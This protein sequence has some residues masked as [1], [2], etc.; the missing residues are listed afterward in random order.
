MVSRLQ[1]RLKASKASKHRT[2]QSR[3]IRGKFDSTPSTLD[4]QMP[5]SNIDLNAVEQLVEDPSTTFDDKLAKALALH[6]RWEY[7]DI[8]EETLE[9]R[10]ALQARQRA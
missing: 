5:P 8:E 7:E 1:A 2:P 4:F 10:E 9:E 6:A 3:N